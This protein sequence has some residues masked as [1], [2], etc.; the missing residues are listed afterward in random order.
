MNIY[1]LC[2]YVLARPVQ[3]NPILCCHR[4][5]CTVR[6]IASL[7]PSL[8]NNDRVSIYIALPHSVFVSQVQDLSERSAT[9]IMNK[10]EIKNIDYSF[11]IDYNPIFAALNTIFAAFNCFLVCYNLPLWLGPATASNKTSLPRQSNERGEK[12]SIRLQSNHRSRL[13]TRRH[14]SACQSCCKRQCIKIW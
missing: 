3:I 6:V 5:H 9:K 12:Q 13:F 4:C 11:P 2:N 14:S 7:Q 8:F 10:E 1:C